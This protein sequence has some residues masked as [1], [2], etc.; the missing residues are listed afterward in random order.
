MHFRPD[1]ILGIP[2]ILNAA[3][4]GTVSLANAVGNGVAD[5]K[6]LYPYVPQIIEYY[7]GEK[8][9]L[10]N[11]PT[12]DLQDDEVRAFVLERLDT[13]VLKP[14]DGSG[15]YGLVMGHQADDEELSRVAEAIQAEPRAW[16]AQPVRR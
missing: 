9:I 1:S 10:P 11:V 6:A 5:D 8:P 13:M 14:V 7:L 16:V 2:G 3:R 15:G 4:A 12:Y